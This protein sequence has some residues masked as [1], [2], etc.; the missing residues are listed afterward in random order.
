MCGIW[1]VC[2]NEKTLLSD[3]DYKG[4]ISDLYVVSSRRGNDASGYVLV[5]DDTLEVF[6][7]AKSP[8]SM[9]K[10]RKYAQGI[11]S[12][13]SERAGRVKLVFGHDRLVT[14]G[15]ECCN[16]NNQPVSK[17]GSV[18]VHNGIVVNVDDLW[19]KYPGERRTLDSDSEII[20]TLLN[21]FLAQG[22]DV[23]PAI[24]RLFNEVYG[25][26]SAAVILENYDKLILM[27]N[28]GSLYY[29]SAFDNNS[30]LFA[31]ERSFLGQ[32]IEKHGIDAAFKPAP[33]KQLGS[34]ELLMVNLKTGQARLDK[35]DSKSILQ[36]RANPFK[37]IDSWDQSQSPQTTVAKAC[38]T[39]E[40]VSHFKECERRVGEI[41]KCS[42]CLLPATFPFIEFDDSGVCNYCH[43]YKKI[44]VK[45]LDRLKEEVAPLAGGV[46]GPNVLIGLSGGRDSSYLLHVAKKE[47]G[48]R[49]LAFSYDWGMLTALARRNQSRLCAKLKVEHVVVSADIKKKRG[50]IRK[51]VAAWLKRPHLGIIPLF[52]AGDKQYFYYANKLMDEYGLKV[53]VFGE[54][55]FETTFF[56]YGFCGIKP[57][58][59]REKSFSISIKAKI[60]MLGFYFGQYMT[61]T[62]YINSSLLDTIG[63]YWSFYFEK[64]RYF[65]L[66]NYL[67]WNEEKVFSTLRR[68]YDWELSPETTSSWRIGD[69]TAAFYNY[70]YYVV[71]GFSENDTFRSNQ[72][73]EGV[74]SR[75]EALALVTK[76]NRP[77]YQSIKWYCDTL[78][79]DFHETLALINRIPKYF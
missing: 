66:Y 21:N 4:L 23:G 69:G 5:S 2:S 51:N 42:K 58:F 6:K 15:S 10:T 59:E 18:C 12:Y 22:G 24:K 73:R 60:Q 50:Y 38:E 45:G 7:D 11:S 71:S 49:P 19:Q 63:A 44:Q 61:N 62:A 1:G 67:M 33:I 9:V 37:V 32:V 52:M 29:A 79:L 77:R 54:N 34:D 68:E 36:K 74:L 53:A 13:L 39:P 72:I 17:G 70:I 76:E 78:G 47:M 56:K 20:P 65:N 40:L 48:L 26:I 16:A 41:P 25:V 35:L 3:A 75:E 30:F 8:S 43:N 64:H 31:S 57:N 28:N 55:L 27:S 14:N 46:K